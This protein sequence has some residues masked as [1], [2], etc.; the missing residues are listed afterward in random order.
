ML[1]TTN[2]SK[3][4][5]ESRFL[6]ARRKFFLVKRNA[7]IGFVFLKQNKGS[8][9]VHKMATGSYRA[10]FNSRITGKSAFAYGITFQGAYQ[11]MIRLFHL[12]YAA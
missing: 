9:T 3:N 8:L 10:I 2:K 4:R 12:K 11:N 6:G 5:R 1:Q 7:K